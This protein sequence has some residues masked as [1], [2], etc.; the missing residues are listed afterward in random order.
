MRAKVRMNT[1]AEELAIQRGI[2]KDPDNPERGEEFFAG[3]QPA[4]DVLPPGMY[5]DLTKRSRGP[6]K[7]AAKAMVTMRLD[8]DV[9]TALR[10]SGPGW[11]GRA[12]AALRRL[13]A[14]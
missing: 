8:A 3:A 1:P 10:S 2:A 5:A 12:N 4:A 13:V 7:R 9:L 11:Q 14:G 6:G